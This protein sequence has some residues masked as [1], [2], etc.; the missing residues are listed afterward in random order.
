MIAKVMIAMIFQHSLGRLYIEVMGLGK[1]SD[2]ANTLM[3]YKNPTSTGMV[4]KVSLDLGIGTDI[5]INAVS[6]CV[7]TE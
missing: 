2:A 5:E 4:T 1:K 3:N 7:A 6:G